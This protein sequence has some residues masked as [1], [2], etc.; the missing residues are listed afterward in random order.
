LFEGGEVTE[1]T[2]RSVLSCTIQDH[3]KVNSVQIRESG[4]Q[5][6]SKDREVK[7]RRA[8]CGVNVPRNDEVLVTPSH[9]SSPQVSL[10]QQ[11]LLYQGNVMLPQTMQK[12]LPTLHDEQFG[13]HQTHEKVCNGTGHVCWEVKKGIQK[14]AA[15]PV[16]HWRT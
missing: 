8:E 15:N 4:E 9:V 14:A 5:L 6:L 12:A 3:S 10:Q 16:D 13:R 2:Q 11:H 7:I 1:K